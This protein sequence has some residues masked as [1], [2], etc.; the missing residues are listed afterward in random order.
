LRDR[1]LG[2]LRKR[3][4][5]LDNVTGTDCLKYGIAVPRVA[6]EAKSYVVN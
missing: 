3:E 1:K 2:I 4:D 6:H 5:P